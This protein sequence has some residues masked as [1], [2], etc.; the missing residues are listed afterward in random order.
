MDENNESP[1]F[2]KQTALKVC[3]SCVSDAK[4]FRKNMDFHI[5]YIPNN[6]QWVNHKINFVNPTDPMVHTQGIEAT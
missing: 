1:H 2:C 4:Q 3:F 6:H 5:I